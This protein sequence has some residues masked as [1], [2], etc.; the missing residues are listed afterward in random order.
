MPKQAKK[1]P[2]TEE[3][4]CDACESNWELIRSKEKGSGP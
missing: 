3:K 4:A 1:E 2:A